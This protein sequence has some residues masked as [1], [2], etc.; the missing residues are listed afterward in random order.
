MNQ[1]L[2]TALAEGATIV[3]AGERRAR[4]LTFEYNE[5]QRQGGAGAWAAPPIVPWSGWIHTLWEEYLYSGGTPPVRLSPWQE[6]VLWE[7]VIR[8]TPASGRSEEH[9][10]ELQSL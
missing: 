3:T 2:Q 4:T 6:R 10:S 7:R 9:T 5:E 1:R 8:E